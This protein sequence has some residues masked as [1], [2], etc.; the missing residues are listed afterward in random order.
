MAIEKEIAAKIA[1]TDKTLFER[2]ARRAW[3]LTQS[4]VFREMYFMRDRPLAVIILEVDSVEAAKKALDSL[5]LV[6]E[7]IIDFDVMP[8]VPYP[9]FA[10]LFKDQ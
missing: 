1:A 6:K 7:K 3:E 5:P 9:G 4:G 2:E 10:R 8:L